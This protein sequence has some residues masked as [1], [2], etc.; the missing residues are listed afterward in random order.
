M[1]RLKIATNNILRNI[2]DSSFVFVFISI[3]NIFIVYKVNFVLEPMVVKSKFIYIAFCALSSLLSAFVLGFLLQIL[4]NVVGKRFRVVLSFLISLF[5]SL[6]FLTDAYVIELYSSP[7]TSNI[8]LSMIS[9]NVSETKEY[10][11]SIQLPLLYEYLLYLGFSIAAAFFAERKLYGKVLFKKL[12]PYN[13]ALGIVYATIFFPRQNPEY[14]LNGVYYWGMDSFDRLAYSY[15]IS[16]NDLKDINEN[17][18][19][20]KNRNFRYIKCRRDIDSLN[21]IVIQ[22]ESLRRNSMHC[23]N[24][25]AENTPNIDSM[26]ASGDIVLFDNCVASGANTA[27]SV[28]R[29]FSFYNNYRGGGEWLEYPT[30]INAMKYSGFYTMWISNQDRGGRHANPITALS[31]CSDSVIF[32][33]SS[34]AVSISSA[35]RNYDEDLIPLL[36]SL[37][38]AKRHH[39]NNLFAI[40]HLMGQHEKFFMRYPDNFNV[41]R[42]RVKNKKDEDI[43]QYYNSILYGDHIFKLIVEHFKKSDA[44]I[45]FTSDHGINLYDNPNS[46]TS[47]GHDANK[48]ASPVPFMVFMSSSFKAKYPDLYD[49]IKKSSYKPFSNDILPETIC[50][51]L[52]IETEYKDDRFHLFSE[53]YKAPQ[54]RRVLGFNSFFDITDIYKKADSIYSIVKQ[55]KK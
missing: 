28:P 53:N 26:I 50:D 16:K 34:N 1:N 38:D 27:I 37:D 6:S 7:M 47:T 40:I 3:L 54:K 18:G 17:I 55:N 24:A 13:I 48:Y 5:Y 39:K 49:A 20:L 30:I 32:T 52:G 45:F 33:Q 36:P 9:T 43:A 4:C 31:L 42:P 14:G 51:A 8:M 21:V 25:L 29:I 22:G 41:F 19:Q 2:S 12:F 10:I 35:K 11:S 15:F 44:I 46:P 23:Y